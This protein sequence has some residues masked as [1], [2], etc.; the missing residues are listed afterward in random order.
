MSRLSTKYRNQNGDQSDV[1]PIQ[2]GNYIRGL[3][4]LC[5][6]GEKVRVG[7]GLLGL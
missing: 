3:K 2:I 5:R 7:R 1:E 4:N 6:L